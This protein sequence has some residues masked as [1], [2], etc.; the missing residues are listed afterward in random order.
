MA[1]ASTT[2]ADLRLG[3]LRAEDRE[4]NM[5]IVALL[6]FIAGGGIVCGCFFICLNYSDRLSNYRRKRSARIEHQRGMHQ[7]T[8]A[9]ERAAVAAKAL[10]KMAMRS[11]RQLKKAN[12]VGDTVFW[13]KSFSSSVSSWDDL[14]DA[15]EPAPEL[16][17]KKKSRRSKS[18]SRRQSWSATSK[19]ADAT[20][21]S[22]SFSQDSSHE[23][24]RGKTSMDDFEV[25]SF[26]GASPHSTE[27]VA[28]ETGQVVSDIM[29]RLGMELDRTQS[30]SLEWRRRHF[31]EMLLKWHPDK[32]PHLYATAVFQKLMVMRGGYLDA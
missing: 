30:M 13:E 16:S 12:T 9:E 28:S 8:I 3:E 17:P 2:R 23:W 4:R 26:Q 11:S 5:V 22:Q 18:K 31:K 21:P 29:A 25:G 10:R 27:P 15:A 1:D 14:E 7:E 20:S 19:H 6:L 32:N 24:S